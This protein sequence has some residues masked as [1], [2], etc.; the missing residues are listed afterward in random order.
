MSGG[1]LLLSDDLPALSR[2]RIDIA[3]KLYPVTGASAI[4]LDMHCA[5]DVLPSKL[6]IWCSDEHSIK[7]SG[8]IVS[9]A[10]KRNTIRVVKGLGSWGCIS[11]GNWNDSI[12]SMRIPLSAFMNSNN[13]FH[14]GG[15]HVFSFWNQ[16]YV[17]IPQRSSGKHRSI[18]TLLAP[19]ESEVFHVKPVSS[20]C[21]QYIGSDF[22]FSCGFE[23][24][25][26]NINDKKIF[27]KLKL[28]LQRSGHVFL[29][30]P[31]DCNIEVLVCGERFAVDIVSTIPLQGE[32][33]R[34]GKVVRIPAF[35][36]LD[37]SDTDGTI[38]I[39]LV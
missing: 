29:F 14:T 11:I 16:S 15:Y 10:K 1:M 13:N 30:I 20:N 6:R 28:S 34:R 21:V 17:W 26:F 23:L 39:S 38:N 9:P 22:H 7:A 37:G 33:N 31:I 27:L 18:S 25:S 2:D 19:H 35:V 12:E 4:P 32:G 8:V 36:K 3:S 24:D 5:S